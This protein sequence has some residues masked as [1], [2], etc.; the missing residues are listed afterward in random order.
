LRAWAF[1]DDYGGKYVRGLA[2]RY[3]TWH[4]RRTA[5]KEHVEFLIPKYRT[6][7]SSLHVCR[8]AE[9]IGFA[10]QLLDARES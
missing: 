3:A 4:I 10:M 5:P 1:R 9:A 7:R 6:F 2:E 8:N